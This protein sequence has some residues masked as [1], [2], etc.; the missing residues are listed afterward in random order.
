MQVS[1]TRA[2]AM[3]KLWEPLTVGMS[4]AV[5][6]AFTFSPDWDGLSKVAVFTAGTT[7]ID[8][9]DTSW[10]S[11]SVCFVPPEVLTTVGDRVNVG[12]YG[13]D[14]DNAIVIPTVWVNLGRVQPAPDPSGD[15]TTDPTLP[16]WAQLQG[17]LIDSAEVDANG[18]L[19]IT[20]H[21]GTELNAGYVVGP[22]GETGPQGPGVPAGG[23]L[24]QILYKGTGDYNTR[25]GDPPAAVFAVDC[26]TSDG[27]F[28]SSVTAGVLLGELNTGK[29]VVL[30]VTDNESSVDLYPVYI[31]A[32]YREQ[33]RYVEGLFAALIGSEASASAF[34]SEVEE[35]D[36]LVGNFWYGNFH[37]LPSG[38]TSNQILAKASDEDFNVY[39]IDPESGGGAV[40]SVNGQT[41]DVVLTASDVGAGTYSKPSGGIPK[42]DLASSVQTSLGKADSAYQKPSGGIPAT[43]LASG[44]IPT[45][46][47]KVSDLTNDSGFV[48]AAGAA[49]A[50]P[51]Q[52]VNGQTGAVSLTIPSTASDVGAIAAPS[53]PASGA[54]LVW[55]GTAWVA[56]T[57]ATWQ[58]GS[59]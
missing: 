9:I 13:T 15:P 4:K 14:A 22:Q 48:N 57:L 19:I 47:T 30:R 7:Q 34:F 29:L 5:P 58:A 59:Y 18:D 56:Q 52:S 39:W 17:Q 26:S 40:S 45:V 16:V 55:N 31:N 49:S 41:G 8:V 42:T 51:V 33:H 20:L 12:V 28:R 38:G 27:V 43:D 44:V 25:W 6:I 11:E 50:A 10:A 2:N 37:M 46:P 23:N 36:F 24:G 54:F 21:S 53:S 35:S 1:V 32:E 3:L